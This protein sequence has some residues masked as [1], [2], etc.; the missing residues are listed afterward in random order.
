MAGAGEEADGVDALGMPRPRVHPA[1]G[2]EGRV[3]LL[4]L[5]LGRRHP[6]A[7]LVVLV[8]LA[9]EERGGPLLLHV[10]G[11]RRL[12]GRALRLDVRLL[13]LG[14]LRGLGHLV[15]PGLAVEQ[16][17]RLQLALLRL[18]L[19]GKPRLLLGALRR[20]LLRRLLALDAARQHALAAVRGVRPHVAHD[21]G[22]AGRG[23]IAQ[24]V[25]GGVLLLKVVWV[26]VRVLHVPRPVVA[27]PRRQPVAR[28]GVRGA[29]HR[30]VQVLHREVVHDLAHRGVL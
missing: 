30:R 3:A 24:R 23:G 29:Q 7:A 20:A 15:R 12:L 22:G 8:L 9:V 1:L 21:L 17:K 14:Q 25:E 19:R 26:H 11:R 5:V 16:R 2:Q 10:V 13:L 4:A 18:R 27:L 6:R 28:V